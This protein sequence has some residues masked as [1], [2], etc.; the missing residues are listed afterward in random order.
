MIEKIEMENAAHVI[1]GRRMKV[2]YV[3]TYDASDV[4]N[5]SGL[6]FYIGKMLEN[7]DVDVE[8]IGNLKTRF[9][10]ESLLK[11]LIYTKLLHKS[12]DIAREPIIAKQLAAQVQRQISD[13]ADIVFSP[14]SIPIA[15]LETSK[16]K[17]FY[18]D[19]TFAGMIGFYDAFSH[20]SC[21]TIKHGNYLEQKALESAALAIYASHWAAQSAINNYN[22]D[23]EKVKVVPFGSNFHS[24][25]TFGEV[26]RIASARS[27]NECHL[28]FLGVD[29]K[30]KGGD[31]AL[32]VAS[33]LNEFGL[34]TTLHVAGI[35]KLPFKR[36]P[37]Y[38]IDYGFV[39]KSTKA[40]VEMI[41]K[42]LTVSHFLILPTRAEAYGL[43][44]CEANSFGVPC[45]TSDVGGVP[46][47]I[48]DDVNGK[49]FQLTDGADLYAQ[50]IYSIFNNK[51]QY[52]ALCCS[53]YNEFEARLNWNK[54]GKEIRKLLNEL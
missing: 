51:Q 49:M 32:S 7:A 21:E 8:Y 26:K 34:K 50:Y 45:I 52:H 44:L 13:D 22:V 43:V 38:V 36:M 53:S 28:L 19:S 54:A 27:K 3:T 15:L 37:E 39:S 23:P 24:K 20:L 41:E 9:N 18:T 35:K 30:R 6:G 33:K 11:K 5:W 17:V 2:S 14:G 10:F 1:A 16:P 29:W 12:F 40:G 4:H 46:T 47:I 31:M 42:L 25:K 48:K